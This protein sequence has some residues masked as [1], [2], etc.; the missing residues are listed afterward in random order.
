M[1]NIFRK[2]I[3]NTNSNNDQEN[4]NRDNDEKKGENSQKES[5][6]MGMLERIAM[7][8][9]EKMSPQEREK[10]AREFFDPKNR[11]KMEKVLKYLK[12]TGKVTDEQIDQARKK[13]NF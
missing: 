10:M 4:K 3:K 11:D 1:W 2:K 5:M 8:K 13:M 7:K 6:K 12:A 9:I